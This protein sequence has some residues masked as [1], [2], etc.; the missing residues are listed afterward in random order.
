MDDKLKIAE[1]GRPNF[2]TQTDNKGVVT[3]VNKTTGEVT[4]FPTEK[5]TASQ[6]KTYDTATRTIDAATN[7]IAA[8]EEAITLSPSAYEGM[9]AQERSTLV[10][11]WVPDFLTSDKAQVGADSTKRLD[12]LVTSQALES[13]KATFGGMPTEG[14]RK[15]LIE[16]QGSAELPHK[17]RIQVWGRAIRMAK[18]KIVRERKRA[19]LFENQFGERYSLNYGNSGENKD[20]WSIVGRQ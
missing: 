1:A 11:S 5:P 8:L 7:S 12:L 6:S 9:S 2:V 15:I 3:Q 20:G 14:E 19:E 17:T 4:K 16:V 13:L 18:A 10:G